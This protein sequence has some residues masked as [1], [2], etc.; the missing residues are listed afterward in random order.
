MRWRVIDGSVTTDWNWN[1]VGVTVKP[2]SE[3]P[4]PD[5]ITRKLLYCSPAI[6]IQTEIVTISGGGMQMNLA[7]MRYMNW[8]LLCC[9]SAISIWKVTAKKIESQI[10]SYGKAN[11][12]VK[13]E[14]TTNSNAVVLWSADRHR[15]MILPHPWS[16]IIIHL[17]L[18]KFWWLLN[19]SSTW[20]E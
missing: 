17:S 18:I 7:E 2:S 19:G 16:T 1:R 5:P 3:S 15:I 14:L 20:S 11:Y 9:P 13:M 8:N 10:E 4:C 6:W 12:D